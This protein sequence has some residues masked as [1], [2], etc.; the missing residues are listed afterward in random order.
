[1]DIVSNIIIGIIINQLTEIVFIITDKID[2]SLKNKKTVNLNLDTKL[3][4]I[5]QKAIAELIRSDRFTIDKDDIKKLRKFLA[6]PEVDAIIRQIY[7]S[8]L[9]RDRDNHIKSIRTEFTKLFCLHSNRSD[10]LQ[11]DI[12]FAEQIFALILS[13]CDRALEIID[14]Q[15]GILSAYKEANKSYQYQILRDELKAIN[16]NLIFLNQQQKPDI[17]TIVEYE[18]KYRKQIA[19]RHGYLIPPNF[20][21]AQKSPID[22]LYVC[23]NFVKTHRYQEV[24]QLSI[25]YFYSI[26]YRVV[27]LGNPGAGKSTFTYKLCNDL[28]T[29]YSEKLLGGRQVTPIH[30]V[31]REYGAAKRQ[32]NKCSILKFIQTKAESKYQLTQP[33]LGT[34]EYLL[35][36][37][38]AIVIFD[39]LDELLDTSDRQEI[40]GDVEAFCSLYPSVPVVVTSREV[41]Y[42]E[43]P[44]DREKF[45]IFYLDSFDREQV[46]EYAN[47]WFSVMET[48]LDPAE[49]DRKIKAFLEESK[50]VPDL[51]SNALILALLCNI[52]RGEG[53]IPRNRPDVYEKCAVMLFERWDKS[54]GINVTLPFQSRILYAIMYLARWI[55]TNK[56]LQEGVT[57]KRLIAKTTEYLCQRQYEN[58][59][60]AEQAACE[61]I[62]FCRG[63]AWVFTD[64]GTLK[65]GEKLY[66]FTHRTFLEY[67]T[68]KHLVRQSRS[69]DKLLGILLPKIAQAEW[70]MVA[71]LA[72]RIQDKDTE[73][74]GDELLNTVIEK[75]NQADGK[76][77]KNLL[78]FAVRC[79][80]FIVPSPKVRRKITEVCIELCID[81]GIKQRESENY[82]SLYRRI[83]FL[84]SALINVADENQANVV[85]SI[86]TVLIKN[87]K[88]ENDDIRSV[89]A[90]E[91][92][93]YLETKIEKESF[94]NCSDYI[95][96]KYLDRIEFLCS[97]SLV[98]YLFIMHRN[99]KI[100]FDKLLE[101]HG[102]NSIFLSCNF[103][104][105]NIYFVSIAHSLLIKIYAN[106]EKIAQQNIYREENLY[107]LGDILISLSTPWLNQ[108][109]EAINLNYFSENIV[110]FSLNRF[111]LDEKLTKSKTKLNF[112]PYTLFGFLGLIMIDLEA[113]Y[114]QGDWIAS[115]SQEDLIPLLNSYPLKF[116]SSTL[117]A[118]FE[119]VDS[120]KVQTELNESNLTSEQ[121]DFILKWTRKEINLIDPTALEESRLYN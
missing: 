71:Q 28:A 8:K 32:D 30:V 103:L 91:I 120:E 86:Q 7:A 76:E 41:G 31:L 78:S 16:N 81:Y 105:G 112:E 102:I 14:K 62:K 59:E 87:I 18:E 74:A 111:F 83:D 95:L 121:K 20:D 109:I 44:L 73:E 101:W 92:D 40:S 99:R 82:F 72:F 54:R 85:N 17:K 77:K 37:G 13:G 80:E 34:F 24:K 63:R 79:L 35:L 10:R 61:F 39:G 42:K 94:R 65:D 97:K 93:F 88:S 36:N 108:N 119:S 27:L 60:E 69:P 25:D 64:T 107:Q 100:S 23:P 29:R 114:P 45:E 113:N 3:T 22:R 75:S 47:K 70:D 116:F 33:P 49:K 118:R 4:P 1:M 98:I 106:L 56:A 66:Q 67:F 2:R 9:I 68:A 46:S 110:N 38:R 21:K 52:Y 43:A 11:E 51:R 89:I 50:L 117:L 96:D 90:L 48:E 53:Y 58:S 115:V 26:V 55:Y 5:L 15:T 6:S 12:K 19:T 104:G 57:E 84:L